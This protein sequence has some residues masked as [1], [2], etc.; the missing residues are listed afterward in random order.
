MAMRQVYGYDPTVGYV[1]H[2]YVDVGAASVADSAR[3][4]VTTFVRGD[5]TRPQSNVTANGGGQV[6]RDRPAA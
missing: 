1:R 5:N 6:R 4:L 3:S 2:H